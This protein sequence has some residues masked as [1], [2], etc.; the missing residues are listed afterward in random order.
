MDMPGGESGGYMDV[1][2]FG[3]EIEDAGA[4]GSSADDV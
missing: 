3:D 4:Y 1:D 2:D